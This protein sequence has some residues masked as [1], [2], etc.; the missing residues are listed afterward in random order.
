MELIVRVLLFLVFVWLH[1]SWTHTN[2]WW[3][4]HS[5]CGCD[6]PHVV[7]PISDCKSSFSRIIFTSFLFLYWPTAVC[8]IKRCK[9]LFPYTC[10]SLC[11]DDCVQPGNEVSTRPD[12]QG[13]EAG[14]QEEEEGGGGGGQEEVGKCQQALLAPVPSQREPQDGDPEEAGSSWQRA[15]IRGPGI[16]DI[17]PV[18]TL[19]N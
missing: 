5:G 6:K 4:P 7:C 1:Q 14:S 16:D 15:A 8:L 2:L 10:F 13:W 9:S 3:A 11:Q 12:R 18:C 19:S 17:Y